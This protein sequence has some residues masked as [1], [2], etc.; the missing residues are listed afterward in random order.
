MFYGQIVNNWLGTNV[1]SDKFKRQAIIKHRRFNHIRFQPKNEIT[2][3]SVV[4][5]SEL[6][7]TDAQR[8]VLSLGLKFTPTP[9]EFNRMQ[10]LNNLRSMT[11]GIFATLEDESLRNVGRKMLLKNNLIQKYVDMLPNTH[12]K[13]NISYSGILRERLL[14]LVGNTVSIS[15]TLDWFIVSEIVDL[16]FSELYSSRISEGRLCST[17][18]S[19]V[20]Q[21][22]VE[23]SPN[24]R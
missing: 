14:A 5:L 16:L 1:T 10:L 9:T 22:G 24:D 4:N 6:Q 11:R 19:C 12:T 2:D 18:S 17:I 21:A 20:E 7:V 3:N 23:A 13:C 15:L 8:K